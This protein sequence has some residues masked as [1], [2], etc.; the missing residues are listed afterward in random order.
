MPSG[1]G[2]W[3]DAAMADYYAKPANEPDPFDP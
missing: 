1:E 2:W 3:S